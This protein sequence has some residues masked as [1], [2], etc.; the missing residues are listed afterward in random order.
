M[1]ACTFAFAFAGVVAGLGD[2]VTVV[3]ELALVLPFEFSAV[4]QAAPKIAK[5]TKV[6]RIDVRRILS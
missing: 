5:A 6:R 1:L 3:L 4:L 2:A